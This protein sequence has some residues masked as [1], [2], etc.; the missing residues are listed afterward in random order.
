M[1]E[2]LKSEQVLA[3]RTFSSSAPYRTVREVLGLPED[4][5]GLRIVDVGAGASDAV[6]GLNEDGAEAFGV[7][8]G[9]DNSR[10]LA[11]SAEQYLRANSSPRDR[12]YFEP[13]WEALQKFLQDVRRNRN[14]YL[15]GY[16][17]SLPFEDSS[18]DIV[19]SLLA[20][21]FFLSMDRAL[22]LQAVQEG[23]RVLKPAEYGVPKERRSL[24]L[25]PWLAVDRD[26]N[27]I[28]RDNSLSLE[29]TLYHRNIPYF[30]EPVSGA[31][32][33]LRIVKPIE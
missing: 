9:F 1:S 8:P 31:S 23:L 25:Q 21:S 5:K 11:R 15:V 26:A 16:A 18:V 6:A 7:D 33:R 13:R 22:L 10:K 27:R 12:E 2:L 14:K 30:I 20:V 28:Q 17:G 24:I 3:Q 29:T 32:P 4:V 19:Y